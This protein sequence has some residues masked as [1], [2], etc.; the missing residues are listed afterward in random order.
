M[1]FLFEDLSG[2]SAVLGPYNQET[3]NSWSWQIKDKNSNLSLILIIYNI[4]S[5]ENDYKTL[6]AVQTKQGYY[7][8]HNLTGFIPFEPDEIIFYKSDDQFISSLIVGRQSTC[9]MYSNIRRDLLKA[10]FAEL[11]PASLMS[12]MQLSL[13]EPFL[14]I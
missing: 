8:L 4:K 5:D 3:E 13:I 11:D 7:E 9:S 10:D 6:V 14:N 1:S 2:I 12:A